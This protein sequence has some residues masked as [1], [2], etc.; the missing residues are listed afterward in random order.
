MQDNK[1]TRDGCKLCSQ[2]SRWKM[3]YV[4][5]T[6]RGCKDGIQVC[7]IL[8]HVAIFM[9]E[10]N[11]D[12][13]WVFHSEVWD[14]L[15][16]AQTSR[17]VHSTLGRGAFSS[18]PFDRE[19]IHLL[20]FLPIPVLH[21]ALAWGWRI[22]TLPPRVSAIFWQPV[23]PSQQVLW[24][25]RCSP[26]GAWCSEQPVPETVSRLIPVWW[27]DLLH[28][29]ESRQHRDTENWNVFSQEWCEDPSLKVL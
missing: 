6:A 8:M 19:Q 26:A 14:S 13:C 5:R 16:V 27:L 17:S 9:S 28:V 12:T 29:Q 1:N 4:W 21:T 18:L 3:A 23:R 2:A 10:E 15:Q 7:W 24:S 20:Y 11:Q 22:H 25:G